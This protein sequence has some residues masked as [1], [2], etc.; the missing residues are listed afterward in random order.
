MVRCKDCTH[1]VAGISP[2]NNSRSN[3][4]CAIARTEVEPKRRIAQAKGEEFPMKTSPRWC[5]LRNENK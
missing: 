2:Y 1:L 4:W 5:P 3:W